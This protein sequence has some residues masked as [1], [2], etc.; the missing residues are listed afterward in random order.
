MAV[1]VNSTKEG[2]VSGDSQF[3]VS[4]YD[5]LASTNTFDI[6]ALSKT[7]DFMATKNYW[8]L[9]QNQKSRIQ[10]DR[11][12]IP[13]SKFKSEYRTQYEETNRMYSRR[14]IYYVKRP[15][16]HYAQNVA[17]RYSEFYQKAV[18][19]ET[20]GKHKEIFAW[21]FLLFVNGELVTT[22]EVL[23]LEADTGIIIDLASKV[24]EHGVNFKQFDSWVKD[25]AMVTVFFLPNFKFTDSVNITRPTVT[26]V[27]K[28]EI[29]FSYVSSVENN[30]MDYSQLNG[31]TLIFHNNPQDYHVKRLSRSTNIFD[32]DQVILF[33]DMTEFRETPTIDLSFINFD[34]EI[35]SRYTVRG[36][37]PYFKV[38]FKMPCPK[39]QLLVF[40]TNT[41]GYTRFGYNI[42]INQYYHNIYELVGLEENEIATIFVFYTEKGVN[43]SETYFRQIETYEKYFDLLLLYKNKSVPEIVKNYQPF[44]FKYTEQ[45][46]LAYHGDVTPSVYSYKIDKLRNAIEEDPWSLWAYLLFLNLS[47]GKYF[48]FMEKLNMSERVR[49]NTKDEPI[50]HSHDVLFD[51]PHYV[52]SINRLFLSGLNWG[53]R[54]F[55]DGLFLNES[56]YIIKEGLDYYYIYIPQSLIAD[57]SVLEIEKYKKFEYSVEKTFVSNMDM[58]TME[59]DKDMGSIICVNDVYLVDLESGNYLPKDTYSISINVTFVNSKKEI[60][61]GY[62]EVDN[63]SFMHLGE[64]VYIRIKKSEYIGK[65]I[66][67]GVHRNLDMEVGK[68]YT[69]PPFTENCYLSMY[70]KNEG[71]YSKSNYRVFRNGR[72]CV[73]AQYEVIDRNPGVFGGIHEVRSLVATKEGDQ[74]VVDHVPASFRMVYYQAEIEESGYVD[75][76]G[77]INLPV[78]LKWYDIYVNGIR[79]SPKNL[80]IISPTR[81]YIKGI[82]SRKNL[83]IMDRD[84]ND[85]VFF[86]QPHYIYDDYEDDRNNTIIDDILDLTNLKDIIDD[87]MPKPPDTDPDEMD[88]II[89][90]DSID[91]I[92]FFEEFMKYTFIDCNLRQLADEYIKERFH[93]LFDENGVMPIDANIHPDG[94]YIK[95]INCNESVGETDVEQRN[96][97]KCGRCDYKKWI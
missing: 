27:Y 77:A 93:M 5:L 16:I 35:T 43:K 57:E 26:T 94:A 64:R 79:L 44:E 70:M 33:G 11:F 32:R 74:L 47:V 54:F 24:D 12:D 67:I 86:L 41:D 55:L 42:T 30:N 37:E 60:V 15:F 8:A 85:D 89:S 62:R 50:D 61:T 96:S 3:M 45:D 31:D 91:G 63:S 14:Y 23:P 56:N 20:V 1:I 46:Y 21:N 88:D 19:Q 49:M 68:S 81:F 84:R 69:E 58:H 51:E 17:Y 48:V 9:Y 82:N 78:S 83:V 53:F 38:E 29:P 7:L 36:R 73:P 52:F 59:L 71:N 65:K 76:D 90:P 18:N 6:E 80:W 13:I 40:V 25:D 34:P 72:F 22:C 95:K 39:D 28:K 97:I 75:L 2:T 4:E 10:M 87:S 92:I 66:Q